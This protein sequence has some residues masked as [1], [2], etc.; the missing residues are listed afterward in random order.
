MLL[1]NKSNV[2]N[3]FQLFNQGQN[4]KTNLFRR[5]G[6]KFKGQVIHKDK[7]SCHEETDA[8]RVF[9]ALLNLLKCEPVQLPY[10][11]LLLPQFKTALKIINSYV[12]NH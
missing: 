3:D 8:T 4:R 11:L 1:D 7:W 2:Y 12:S 5:S 6:K 10:L 9:T